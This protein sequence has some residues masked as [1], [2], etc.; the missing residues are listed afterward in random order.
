MLAIVWAIELTVHRSCK[1]MGAPFPTRIVVIIV[2][3]VIAIGVIVISIILSRSSI[4]MII[5]IFVFWGGWAAVRAC[6]C[7]IKVFSLQTCFYI[8]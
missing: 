7:R 6:D 3:I 8:I 1:L 4:S 2:I 5:Y